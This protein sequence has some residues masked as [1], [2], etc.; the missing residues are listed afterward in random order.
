MHPVDHAKTSAK[1]FGGTPDLYVKIHDWLDASKEH[2]GDWRHRALRHHSQGIFEAE[3]VFGHT[4]TNSDGKEVPVRYIAE[5]HIR[6]DCGGR[7]PTMADWFS[8]IPRESWM[9]KGYKI[10]APGENPSGEAP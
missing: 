4:I 3:R 6:E 2:F 9:A 5:Q 8:K 1:L 10:D 7:I